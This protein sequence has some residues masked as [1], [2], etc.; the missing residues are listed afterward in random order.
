MPIAA[1]VESR[2]PSAAI[3]IQRAYDWHVEV[4]RLKNNYAEDAKTFFHDEKVNA[5]AAYVDCPSSVKVGTDCSGIDVP[6]IAMKNMGVKHRHLSFR[7]NGK[8][9]R[10]QFMQI[11]FQSPFMRIF[12]LVIRVESLKWAYTSRAFLANRPVRWA[13]K[14][15]SMMPKA[16]GRYSTI[17]S[18][19]SGR[20]FQECLFWKM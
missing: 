12:R 20:N 8:M 5:S 13:S 15:V 6:I 16:E 4:N 10:K 17:F 7:D 19:T 1:D 18:S 9:S 11:S 3:Y 14:K 2:R